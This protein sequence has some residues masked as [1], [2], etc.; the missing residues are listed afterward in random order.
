[1]SSKQTEPVVRTYRLPRELHTRLGEYAKR[2]GISRNAA[3]IVL[4]EQSLDV[5]RER[6]Q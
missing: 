1:M 3:L 2:R 4:V 6:A 5:N